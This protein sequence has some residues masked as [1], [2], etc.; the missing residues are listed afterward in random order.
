MLSREQAEHL[1]YAYVRME[2]I[3]GDKNARLLAGNY[4]YRD[5]DYRQKKHDAENHQQN[6]RRR[7]LLVPSGV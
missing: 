4:R 5:G 2:N 7:F 6:G 1:L 3:D